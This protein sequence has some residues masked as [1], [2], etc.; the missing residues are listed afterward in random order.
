MR[1]EEPRSEMSTWAS[2][3]S[4]VSFL[5]RVTAPSF[6]WLTFL[7]KTLDFPKWLHFALLL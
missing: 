3:D 7:A 6:L 4:L 1:G 2:S 5:V